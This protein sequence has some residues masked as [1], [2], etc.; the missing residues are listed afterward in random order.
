MVV[1]LSGCAALKQAVPYPSAAIRGVD[2]DGVTLSALTLRFDVEVG[3]PYGS[4]LPVLGFDYALATRGTRFL[5]GAHESQ[6]SIPA[7]ATR[8]LPLLVRIPF[9]GLVEVVES[10]SPGAVF[11]FE[12]EVGIKVATPLVGEVRLPMAKEGEIRIP[13]FP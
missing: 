9:S 1:A 8:V 6:E 5:E 10:V 7:K 13:S 3:N 2:V 4:D 11:P 12:A